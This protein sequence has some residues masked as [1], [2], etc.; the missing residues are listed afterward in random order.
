[1]SFSKPSAGKGSSESGE[2][3]FGFETACEETEGLGVSAFTGAGFDAAVGDEAEGA[4]WEE[5]V[6]AG[7]D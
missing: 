5:T 3:K 7:A 4:A 1:L 6:E 2:G